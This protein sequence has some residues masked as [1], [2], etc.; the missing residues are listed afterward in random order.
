MFLYT[1]PQSQPPSA[2]TLWGLPAAQTKCGFAQFL[3]IEF[4][5]NPDLQ[6]EICP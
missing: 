1:K 3:E 6:A 5:Q 2:R 4:P